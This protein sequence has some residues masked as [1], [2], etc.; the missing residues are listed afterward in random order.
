MKY[1]SIT[2]CLAVSVL[3]L[4]ACESSSSYYSGASYAGPR[5]AGETTME[6]TMKKTTKTERVFKKHMSK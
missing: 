6:P 3:A 5:T 2:L 4:A 1:L